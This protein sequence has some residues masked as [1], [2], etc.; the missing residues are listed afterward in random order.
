L[1]ENSYYILQN[2]TCQP[3][4]SLTPWRFTWL[5]CYV[6][7]SKDVECYVWSS[8]VLLSNTTCNS[9]NMVG[10]F[11][12]SSGIWTVIGN[13]SVN[14]ATVW[15]NN[16]QIDGNLNINANLNV[17]SFTVIGDVT[18]SKGSFSII[19]NGTV[20][21]SL[22]VSESGSLNI[23]TPLVIK[24]CANLNGSLTVTTQYLSPN[25]TI[26]ALTYLCYDGSF[27]DTNVLFT[28]Y[29]LAPCDGIQS[30][31]TYDQSSLYITY[32][33]YDK[34]SPSS[35]S[36]NATII[37]ICIV[38]PV[39]ALL[40]AGVFLRYLRPI[41]FPFRDEPHDYSHS[42]AKENPIQTPSSE[43]SEKIEDS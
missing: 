19:K 32:N 21:G 12:S 30:T 10:F 39:V 41:C 23:S 25:Q 22:T 1:T 42:V 7:C 31:A 5:A 17:T 11:C 14:D 26:L 4:I 43:E 18:V 36:L 37:S 9:S 35:E 2:V 13:I 16:F 27:R 28:N 15:D 38:V 6:T 34:C 24:N 40:I 3:Y 8:P 33:I 20:Y 29:T